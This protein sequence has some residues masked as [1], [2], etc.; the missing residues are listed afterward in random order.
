MISTESAIEK[1][2]LSIAEEIRIQ[3]PINVTF[4]T[5]IEQLGSFNETPEG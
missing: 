1:M 4:L 3:A 2:T 5:L